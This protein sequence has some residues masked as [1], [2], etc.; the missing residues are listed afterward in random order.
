ML[1]ACRAMFSVLF[2][3]YI[4]DEESKEINL[5]RYKKR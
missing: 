1:T 5:K 4:S 3:C 2:C